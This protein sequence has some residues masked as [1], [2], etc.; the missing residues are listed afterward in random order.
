METSISMKQNLLQRID[1]SLVNLIA[2]GRNFLSL[3]NKVLQEIKNTDRII[4][5]TNVREV[6][7]LFEMF[8]NSVLANPKPKYW[9]GEIDFER[10]TSSWYWVIKN[11]NIESGSSG[12][13]S[14]ENTMDFNPTLPI[15]KIKYNKY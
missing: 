10:Y 2:E 4:V 12:W 1:D 3:R 13:H 7:E 15:V 5:T 8:P 6:K 14:L 9:S 11:E